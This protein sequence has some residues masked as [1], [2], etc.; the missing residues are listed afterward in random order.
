MKQSS[1]NLLNIHRVKQTFTS[2]VNIDTVPFFHGCPRIPIH[3]LTL[4]HYQTSLL[5]LQCLNLIYSC[6]NFLEGIMSSLDFLTN[7]GLIFDCIVF[8][9]WGWISGR[10]PSVIVASTLCNRSVSIKMNQRWMLELLAD[11]T[12]EPNANSRVTSDSAAWPR[13]SNK[14]GWSLVPLSSPQCFAILHTGWISWWCPPHKAHKDSPQMW[15]PSLVASHPMSSG[16]LGPE[17]PAAL[18][19]SYGWFQW[20]MVT[21]CHWRPSLVRKPSQEAWC[22]W[23]G[24]LGLCHFFHHCCSSAHTSLSPWPL[25]CPPCP[26]WSPPA[27]TLRVRWSWVLQYSKRRPPGPSGTCRSHH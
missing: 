19:G 10:C 4:L 22:L 14:L 8:P 17:R 27:E 11:P 25:T 24:A 18:P 13:W 12:A 5:F 23:A 21:V 7:K 16:H 3:I 20:D 6:N 2:Y 1:M 15:Q 26:Q 9:S